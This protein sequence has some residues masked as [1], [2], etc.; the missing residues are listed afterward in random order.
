[1]TSIE[2]VKIS[3]MK[4]NVRALE[5]FMHKLVFKFHRKINVQCIKNFGNNLL[6]INYF[7][8]I[9]EILEVL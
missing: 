1:M 3:R 2:T 9:I 5:D 8:F 7:D 6:L 4:F